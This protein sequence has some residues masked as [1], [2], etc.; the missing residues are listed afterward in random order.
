MPEIQNTDPPAP[1]KEEPKKPE[2]ALARIETE[3]DDTSRALNA[4]ATEGNFLMAQ[5]MAAALAK[6]TLVPKEFQNNIPNVLIAMEIASR[7]GASVFMVMQHL[8]IIHGRPSWR[9]TFLI[10]TVNASGKF[11]PLRPRWEGKPGTPE[12]GCR[13]VAKD[14]ASGEEC[15]GTLITLKMAKDEGWSTKNGSKWLTM[16]D[17]MLIYRAASFWTRVYAPELSLGMQS[18]EEVLDV[19]ATPV[20]PHG[21]T[22]ELENALMGDVVVTADGEVVS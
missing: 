4:F 17:Q 11:S 14:L 10:A 3:N 7:V 8:D 9:A 13:M 22:R 5:R 21:D 16:P 2:A 18:S 19:I 20:L 1:P 6:S 15:L 12:W